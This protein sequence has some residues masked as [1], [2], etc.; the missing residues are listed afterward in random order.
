[1]KAN[2]N[3][4]PSCLFFSA[5][6]L[7]NVLRRIVNSVYEETGIA[8]PHIYLLII[9]NQYAGITITELSEKLDIAPS[10]CTR[11]ENTLV[12]KGI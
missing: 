2:E 5:N 4:L 1:M 3:T 9:V 8:T 11:I 7:A 6:R 12:K 10:T